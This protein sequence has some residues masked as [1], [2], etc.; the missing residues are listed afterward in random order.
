MTMRRLAVI[1]IYRDGH[2][3]ETCRKRSMCYACIRFLTTRE[4]FFHDSLVHGDTHA[5][6]QLG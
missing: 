2:V 5:R 6:T 3:D 4:S 1:T